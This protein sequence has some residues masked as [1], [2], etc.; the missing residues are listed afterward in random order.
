ML[1]N[2]Q[3]GN[4][5][6]Y[7]AE[8]ASGLMVQYLS[9]A[10]DS[11]KPG[12]IVYMRTSWRPGKQGVLREYA[13]QNA[14]FTYLYETGSTGGSSMPHYLLEMGKTF[15]TVS[16]SDDSVEVEIVGRSEEVVRAQLA[17]FQDLAPHVELDSDEREMRVW[18]M[19]PSGGTSSIMTV[20]ELVPDDVLGNYAAPTRAGLEKLFALKPP[21]MGR[22]IV[23]TG[24]PGTG[25]TNAVRALLRAWRWCSVDYILDAEQ[26]FR[27]P[28]YMNSVLR[29]ASRSETSLA[30]DKAGWRLVV[31]EDA[32]ELL[33]CE[34]RSE[35]GPGLSRFL[36]FTDGLVGGY[37]KS[38]FL[39]TTN[40]DIGRLH[41]AVA[42]PGRCIAH[43]EF[44]KLSIDEAR[45]WR[46]AKGLPFRAEGATLA[47]LYAELEGV[48]PAQRAANRAGF[49]A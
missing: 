13:K 16:F 11:P 21:P 24:Q 39:V 49:L 19:S 32:G 23:W 31:L 12:P 8:F 4:D 46:E 34:A 3:S 22:I 30:E 44:D 2:L 26:L 7:A 40:E 14:R 41:S 42:R 28:G 5:I 9:H 17:A 38:L 36:N 35:Y 25:K 43:V 15:C 27:N 48:E 10:W 45:D 29:G 18:Q 1:L 20:R 47:E 37:S 33:S 6:S